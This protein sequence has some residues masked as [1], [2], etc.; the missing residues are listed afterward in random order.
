M[1]IID[2][3]LGVLLGF[4]QRRPSYTATLT[5]DYVAPVVL[6]GTIIAKSWVERGDGKRKWW[7][8]CEIVHWVVKESGEEGDGTW[9]V[10]TRGRGLWL[11]A[12]EKL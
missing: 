9:E 6:P 7:V 12:R 1:T 4:Y 2:E 10:C 5:V 11:E 8:R 3:V